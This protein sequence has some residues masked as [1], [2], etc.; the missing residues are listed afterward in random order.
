MTTTDRTSTGSRLLIVGCAL[1]V[2][3]LLCLIIAGAIAAYFY[4]IE[5]IIPVDLRRSE[6]T[7]TT[8]VSAASPEATAT[9]QA[10]SP[11]PNGTA[12]RNPLAG[13]ALPTALARESESSRPQ[14]TFD[15]PAS[16]VQDPPPQNGLQQIAALLQTDY[17]A[18]DYYEASR[19][20]GGLNVGPRTVTAPTYQVGDRQQF[21]LDDRETEAVLLAVTEHAYFWVEES[22]NL[23]Q[24]AVE[25]AARRF[26]DD[27]YPRLERVFGHEWRPG[28]DND[29]HFSVLHLDYMDSETDELGHFNS[30]DE[31]PSSFL[32]GSNQQELVYLN[33]SNLTIGSDL[34]FGTLV[35]E[36]QHLVQ[37]HL[38]PNETAW[39][40]EG[41]SQLA[42]IY[43]GLDTADTIDYLLAPDVRLTT[44][45]Y[46]SEDVYAHYAATYLF[47]VYLWEQ[48]G[49]AA[50]QELARHP[51]NGIASVDAVLQGFRPELNLEQLMANWVAANLLDDAAAGP[52]YAYESLQLRAIVPTSSVD[53]AP[54]E[55]VHT[56]AQFGAHYID[57]GIA[58][59][60]T[61]AFAGD[62]TARF[63]GTTAY[64]G[65]K[66]WFA[67]T[68]DS[69]NA[70]LT[71]R[72]DLTNLDRATLSFWTWY[73]LDVD[74][75]YGYVSVSADEGQTWQLLALENG[76]AGDYGM[77][78]NGRSDRQ[79]GATQHGWVQETISLDAYTG[80]PLLVRFELLTYFDSDARGLALDD[81]AIPELNYMDDVENA[82]GEWQA[83][84]FVAVGEHLPQRWSVQLIQEGQAPEVIPLELN[85]FNQGQWTMDINPEGAT[86]AVMPLTPFATEPANYWL[87][88]RQ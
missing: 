83:T 77:A 19:R 22:L 25:E 84:G 14:F 6:P 70:Q 62:T 16:I 51:A 20:L 76:S 53:F 81:I 35:H 56:L 64:S 12:P 80:G 30:G 49:E 87:A 52:Q 23:D 61:L 31:Y 74:T 41:L 42:E 39:L 8:A 79:P 58:G 9:D 2:L 71:Q 85:A 55:E 21:Y 11:T 27:Y 4:P 72:F 60:T 54:H 44:W 86:L 67:P 63:L 3:C 46:S 47:C 82:G 75:D 40:N 15:L 37:W 38:D 48:L 45:S 59:T 17:P 78:F 65:E 32:S 13:G 69:I 26:E 34:Y 33:M 73:D 66:V 28:V 57:L 36:Y 5:T 43:V 10:A 50:I 24:T 7:P 1:V 29:P 68:Q 18:H 88:V